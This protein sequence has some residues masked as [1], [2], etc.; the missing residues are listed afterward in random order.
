MHLIHA[1]AVRRALIERAHATGRT[2]FT[3]VSKRLLLQ[4]ERQVA[5]LIHDVVHRHPSR[6]STLGPL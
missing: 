3:R 1:T 5:A 2:R 6:G 4:I